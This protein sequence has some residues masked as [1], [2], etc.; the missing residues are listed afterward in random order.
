[1][2][3]IGKVFTFSASHQLAFGPNHPCSRLHGHNYTVEIELRAEDLD[4]RGAIVDYGDLRALKTYLDDRYDHRHLND[5]MHLSPTAENL[6]EQIF[7]FAV[8]NWSETRS[9]TVRE[10]PS[11][12]ARFSLD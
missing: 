8:A 3:S 1:M 7:R 11:T 10:T 2:Y 6:A 9:V 12:W 4:V 5:V